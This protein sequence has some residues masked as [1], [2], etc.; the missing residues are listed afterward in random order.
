[1]DV[2][3]DRRTP[4]ELYYPMFSD[5]IFGLISSLWSWR[6]STIMKRTR[7]SVSQALR[8]P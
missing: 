1:V 2:T 8:H 7:R 6:L 5:R 3:Y 4:N